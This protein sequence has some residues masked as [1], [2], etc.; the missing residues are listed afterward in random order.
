VLLGDPEGV[1]LMQRHGV[2]YMRLRYRGATGYD[3][4]QRLGNAQV[5]KALGAQKSEL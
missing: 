5:L 4:A 2:D 1:L 3:L